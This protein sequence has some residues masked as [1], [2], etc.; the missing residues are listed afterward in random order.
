MNFFF[1]TI[2]GE[3]PRLDA[4]KP[5]QPILAVDPPGLQSPP[6]PE[7]L[8][9][10]GDV[11]MWLTIGVVL[12]GCTTWL[13]KQLS[14]IQSSIAEQN[15][16]IKDVLSKIQ[17][18]EQRL[19]EA[20]A[21]VASYE[22]KATRISF[23]TTQLARTADVLVDKVAAIESFLERVR[24]PVVNE[25]GKQVTRGYHR[26]VKLELA[27]GPLSC[28]VDYDLLPDSFLDDADEDPKR[29]TDY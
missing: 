25:D 10:Q 13:F 15:W 19:E 23:L 26:K 1:R 21:R 20:D 16:L 27:Q 8:V 3:P 14:G 11:T 5:Q 17:K 18:L 24:V 4:S 28:S 29:P 2:N 6:N 7:G 22:R 12:V 9:S